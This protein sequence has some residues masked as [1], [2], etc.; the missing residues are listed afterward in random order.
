MAGNCTGVVCFLCPTV[1]CAYTAVWWCMGCGMSVAVFGALWR[2]QSSAQKEAAP[3][4]VLEVYLQREDG[5]LNLCSLSSSTTVAEVQRIFMG[6]R[7]PNLQNQD[8]KEIPNFASFQES[9][10]LKC[11]LKVLQPEQ[12]LEECGIQQHATIRLMWRWGLP[13]GGACMSTPSV[14]VAPAVTADTRG[15][16]AETGAAA[17]SAD[18]AGTAAQT[19]GRR[20]VGDMA[21]AAS[22]ATG[23]AAPTGEGASASAEEGGGQGALL[24][25]AAGNLPDIIQAILR[26]F[27][28]DLQGATTDWDGPI[29]PGGQTWA[30]VQKMV[31]E[32]ARVNFEGLTEGETRDRCLRILQDIADKEWTSITSHDIRKIVL[33]RADKAG[34]CDISFLRPFFEREK[35]EVA[36]SYQWAA[37]V[38][39]VFN[40]LSKQFSNNMQVRV[41]LDILFNPQGESLATDR[42]VE[43]TK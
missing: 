35:P 32:E 12:T 6:I 9:T 3:A 13:G 34:Y 11:K 7:A 26:Q 16:A 1:L 23:E 10:Y 17:V 15:G 19:E 33:L 28:K 5:P 29:W 4:H 18:T 24:S 27:I 30:D 25:F 20:D 14:R 38:K 8:H 21:P 37:K 42:V 36:I 40:G 2:A 41:W 43:I 22:A 31:S 39:D